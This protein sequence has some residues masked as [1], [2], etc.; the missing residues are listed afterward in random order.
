MDNEL[1]RKAGPA[2][3]SGEAVSI[4][5]PIRNTDRTAC[6]ML[7]AE[8][9]RRWGEEGLAEDTIEL[10]FDGSAGQ[11]FGAFLAPGISVR[12]KGDANDYFGKGLS[13]GRIV[14][15]PPEGSTFPPEENIIVGN[16]SLYGATGGEVG[17]I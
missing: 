13:G 10:A 15:V 6:T 4:S 7:S 12:L 5:I 11:S 17:D 14:V 9:S 1:I 16:V 3:E 8:V 2:L